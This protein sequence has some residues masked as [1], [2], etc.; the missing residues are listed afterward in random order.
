MFDRPAPA[1]FVEHVLWQDRGHDL[2]DVT[3][4]LEVKIRNLG[5]LE[6][7]PDQDEAVGLKTV[8]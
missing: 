4:N 3:L 8:G 2:A 6:Q 5:S 1:R 7:A